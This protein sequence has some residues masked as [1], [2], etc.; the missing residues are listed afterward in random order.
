MSEYTF[1]L[2]GED[3]IVI[4]SPSSCIVRT[5][6]DFET[7]FEYLD[8][9]VNE[10]LLPPLH[11]KDFVRW[12][13]DVL[14]YNPNFKDITVVKNFLVNESFYIQIEEAKFKFLRRYSE[15]IERTWAFGSTYEHI[16][17]FVDSESEER[18][19]DLENRFRVLSRVR[20][21][22]EISFTKQLCLARLLNEKCEFLKQNLK[23]FISSSNHLAK[24]GPTFTNE[25]RNKEINNQLGVLAD[26]LASIAGLFDRKRLYYE[27]YRRIKEKLLRDKLQP[28]SKEE[29]LYSPQAVLEEMVTDIKRYNA[30]LIKFLERHD[31][32]TGIELK[33]SK[34][35]KDINNIL[36]NNAEG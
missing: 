33:M 25:P 30:N 19:Y 18:L 5:R 3:K 17:I 26:I 27:K 31:M 20:E 15:L 12:L 32:V 10:I 23:Y 11:T 13:Q 6:R 24:M 8:S 1:Q 22:L 29:T 36:N 35:I 16:G 28:E 9:T 4:D 2:Q 14:Y 34:V 21:E 7:F